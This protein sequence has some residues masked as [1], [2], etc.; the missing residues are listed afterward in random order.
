M[1]GYGSYKVGLDR[2]VKMPTLMFS[3]CAELRSW[4]APLLTLHL[5]K[6]TEIVSY[7]LI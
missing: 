4:Q 3:R 2:G 1:S 7:Y 5:A 6:R